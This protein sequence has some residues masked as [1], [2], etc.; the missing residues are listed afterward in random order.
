MMAPPGIQP[1]SP[2][3]LATRMVVYAVAFVVFVF[4]LGPAAFHY[5]ARAIGLDALGAKLFGLLGAAAAPV[6]LAVFLLGFIAY[7]ICS[8][9]LVIVGK[10]PFVEFDPPREFVATGPYRW[11]RNPV[12]V[13]LLTT[14]FGEALYFRSIGILIFVL[15]GLPACHLLV[16]RIEEP[17]LRRR[18][19][20][21]YEA[22]CQAVHRWLPSPPRDWADQGKGNGN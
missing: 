11:L 7:L 21:S 15:L 17:R 20:R 14:G 16:T 10:G 5:G 6:G 2:A 12:V 1:L 18:F 3:A 22:Y 13:A 19:G 4:G 8:L 9:W